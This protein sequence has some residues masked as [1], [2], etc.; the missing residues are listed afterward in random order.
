MAIAQ[1]NQNTFPE[2]GWKNF[3]ETKS[4]MRR[5]IWDVLKTLDPLGEKSVSNSIVMRDTR[6]PIHVALTTDA[7]P[8]RKTRKT[9]LTW[10]VGGV[11]RHQDCQNCG[12]P[13]GLSRA[14]ALECSGANVYL[15]SRFPE[16]SKTFL[17]KEIGN[18]PLRLTFLDYLLHFHRGK[19]ENMAEKWNFYSE[20]T[21]SIGKIY[22][23]CL[24]FQIDTS[25]FWAKPEPA[26]TTQVRERVYATRRRREPP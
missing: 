10:L 6:E 17:D 4:L 21:F 25:G 16:E 11:A 23:K 12:A 15:H 24:K 2:N 19:S 13:E 9:I 1:K 3:V 18:T 8:N 7:F 14:H 5:K 20:L 26:E 22:E